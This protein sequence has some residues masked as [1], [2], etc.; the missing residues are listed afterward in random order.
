FWKFDIADEEYDLSES[1]VMLNTPRQVY[2]KA[3]ELRTEIKIAQANLEVAEQDVKI[4]R[5]AY[6]PSLTGFYNLNTRVTYADY[7]SFENGQV[8][9]VT[10]PP[11]WNQFWDNKGHSFG[12]QLNIPIFNGFATRNNVRKSK[13]ALERSMLAVEREGLDLQRNVYTAYTDVQGAQK[14]YEAAVSAADAR[15]EAL[16][17]GK[18]RYEVGLINV[19]DLNQAQTLS[20]NAQSEVLRTKYDYIFKVKIL[21]FYFGIPITQN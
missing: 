16:V 6:Q 2:D 18:E 10:P 3:R 1:E 5:A 9:S 13:I 12:F 15:K 19:F 14:A 8:V 11:F 7:N 17:Y 21:E 4:A 20:A